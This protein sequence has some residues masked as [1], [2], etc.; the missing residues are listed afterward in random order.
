MFGMVDSYVVIPVLAQPGRDFLHEKFN[1]PTFGD[2]IPTVLVNCKKAAGCE[3]CP[4][5]AKS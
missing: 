5:F 1:I 3:L 2:I 4:P